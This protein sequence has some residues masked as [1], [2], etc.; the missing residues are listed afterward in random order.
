MS[1]SGLLIMVHLPTEMAR[2]VDVDSV[3]AFLGIE[4]T[5]LQLEFG[6]VPIDPEAGLVSVI[7]DQ[8]VFDGLSDVAKRFIDGPYANPKISPFGRPD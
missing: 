7:I 5:A 2:D 1:E 3:A 8:S 4:P 6:V